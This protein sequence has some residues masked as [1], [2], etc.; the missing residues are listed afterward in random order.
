MRRHPRS[1]AAA[2]LV[3]LSGNVASAQGLVPPAPRQGY[4]LS[5]VA[6]GA[7]LLSW[8]EE[9]GALPAWPGF[10]SS[11]R[12]GQGVTEWL[13][14]GL[15]VDYTMGFGKKRQ[16]FVSGLGVEATVLLGPHLAISAGAGMGVSRLEERD[17]AEAE[18]LGGFGSLFRLAGA[19]AFFP[20]HDAG[21]GGLTLAPTVAVELAPADGF[22]SVAV[23]FGLEVGYWF[24]LDRSRL[25]LPDDQAFAPEG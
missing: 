13:A 20:L 23:L 5:L 11:L 9:Q 10:G 22:R 24:G 2:L 15:S 1:I 17:D 8:D 6:S 4:Y 25:A 12:A 16:G 21:S 19:W 3:L 7:T 14:L 18:P